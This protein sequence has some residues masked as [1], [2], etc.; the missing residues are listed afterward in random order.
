MVGSMVF[1]VIAI[2]TQ[3]FDWNCSQLGLYSNFETC[4]LM[5]YKQRLQYFI[6][7]YVMYTHQKAMVESSTHNL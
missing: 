1:N 5:I 4:V 6:Y 2:C 3:T 7:V